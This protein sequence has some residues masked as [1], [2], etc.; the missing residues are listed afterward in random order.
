MLYY[1]RVSCCVYEYV[2]A[3][4][5]VLHDMRRRTMCEFGGV[6]WPVCFALSLSLV[7][8]LSG[9]ILLGGCLRLSVG[10]SS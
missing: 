2:S 10:G 9:P 1:G 5:S 4:C 6:V 7:N 8:C 3:L